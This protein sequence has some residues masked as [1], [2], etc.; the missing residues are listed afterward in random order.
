MTPDSYRPSKSSDHRRFLVIVS[1]F[2]SLP[3]LYVVLLTNK[4]LD[5]DG[6][7]PVLNRRPYIMGDTSAV[8]RVRE[9][10]IAST[11]KL[12]SDSRISISDNQSWTVRTPRCLDGID[13]KSR[14]QFWTYWD[15]VNPALFDA[16]AKDGKLLLMFSVRGHLCSKCMI[17]KATCTYQAK[18]RVTSAAWTCLFRDETAVRG[19]VVVNRNGWVNTIIVECKIPDSVAI[20]DLSAGEMLSVSF[21]EKNG[22]V[23]TYRD[24]PFCR[25]PDPY[26]WSQPRSHLVAL[27]EQGRVRSHPVSLAICTMV[28]SSLRRYEK[29][30]ADLLVEWIAYH[31]LQ[32]VE[33]FLIFAHEDPAP[34]RRLL[35]PYIAEGLAEVIDWESPIRKRPMT[36]GNEDVAA[37]QYLQTTSC[38]HRYRGLAEWVGLFDVDEFMQPLV[39]GSTVRSTVLE[40]AATADAKDSDVAGLKVAGVYFFEE[41]RRRWGK[42]SLM[43]QRHFKRVDGWR[44][45]VGKYFGRPERIQ[46]SVQHGLTLGGKT[47]ELDPERV[48]RFN[49]YRSGRHG[50]VTDTSMRQH[51]EGIESEIAR[52]YGTSLPFRLRSL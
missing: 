49:H 19:N 40:A 17:G 32:G 43:T 46:L 14:K 25:Y 7:R 52:A 5:L 37:V 29:S 21:Q 31:K 3:V 30:N 33:H 24:V 6:F 11:R 42:H 13:T 12:L 50:R 45:D 2:C 26:V 16:F 44:F 41:E 35:A 47:V 15:A 34:L 20:S 27:T 23:H 10:S 9:T 51:R 36:Q 38:L 39:N 18:A 8:Y 1:M 4:G 48:M 22:N 28:K